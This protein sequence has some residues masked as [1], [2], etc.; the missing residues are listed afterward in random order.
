MVVVKELYDVQEKEECLTQLSAGVVSLTSVPFS[1]GDGYCL[2]SLSVRMG[3][4]RGGG[5]VTQLLVEEFKNF[6]VILKGNR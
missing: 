5:N 1:D 6:I 3:R 2:K 4:G